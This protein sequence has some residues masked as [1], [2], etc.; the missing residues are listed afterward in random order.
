MIAIDPIRAL[1]SDVEA[2][3]RIGRQAARAVILNHRLHKVPM[4]IGT[5]DGRVIEVDPESVPLPP[6]EH[7]ESIRLDG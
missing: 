2:M 3:N 5:P 7:I 1:F 6:E 4:V